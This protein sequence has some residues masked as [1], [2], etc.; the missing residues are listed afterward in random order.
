M[1]LL[2]LI[3][4]VWRRDVTAEEMKGLGLCAAPVAVAISARKKKKLSPLWGA[5][6]KEV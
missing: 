2:L 4:P 3:A 5:L 6:D 1:L